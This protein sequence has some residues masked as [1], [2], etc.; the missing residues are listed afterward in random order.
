MDMGGRGWVITKTSYFL[1]HYNGLI[2]HF[3]T[4]FFLLL[5]YLPVGIV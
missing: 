1:D 3:I 5:A 2:L 4:Y